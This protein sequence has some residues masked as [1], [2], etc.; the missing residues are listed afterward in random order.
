MKSVLVFALAQR[1]K[2]SRF[3]WVLKT[4]VRADLKEERAKG[5]QRAS[6]DQKEKTKDMKTVHSFS[7]LSKKKDCGGFGQD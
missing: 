3:I 7:V 1:H 2:F 6:L 4:G 5:G